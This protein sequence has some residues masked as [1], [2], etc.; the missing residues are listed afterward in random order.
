MSNADLLLD[1]DETVWL[2]SWLVGLH[3]DSSGGKVMETEA[4][5][6]LNHVANWYIGD[7]QTCMA[8]LD[9][10]VISSTTCEIFILKNSTIG[11][12]PLRQQLSAWKELRENILLF[13]RT[14]SE[15][16]ALILLQ[17]FMKSPQIR[18]IQVQLL[19]LKPLSRE[20]S[21]VYL[22]S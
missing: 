9:C 17:T 5:P 10:I 21:C 4:R 13:S 8:D 22:H 15:Y 16:I 12:F 14:M 6:E 1:R 2:W 20:F 7:W 3:A 11:H 19:Y 18:L